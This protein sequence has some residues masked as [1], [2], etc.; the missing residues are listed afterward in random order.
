MTIQLDLQ[1]RNPQNQVF[2]KKRT[3]SIDQIGAMVVDTWNYHWCMTAAERCGSFALR[4]NHALAALRS[5]GVQIFW[6]PTDVADQYVGTPQREK[7]V[8]VEPHP[9][10]TPLDIQFPTLDCYGAGGCMCGSGIDCR[11]NYGWDGM[12]PN[13][14][15]D[16]LDLIVEG[17]QE[18][19]SWCQKL[20]INCLI[21][22]GFHTNVCTTGKP[23]GIGPM[24]RIGIQSILARDMTDAI[25]GY[26][27]SEGQHPDRGT[28]EVIQQL[29]SIVPTIHL[30]DELRKL[31]QWDDETPIDPVRITPWGTLN[32]PYRFEESTVV[33]LSA[34]LNQGCQ[35]YYT[36]DGTPPDEKSSLYTD[37]FPVCET[38]TI[39]TIAYRGHQSIC[40]ES[41]A[42]FVC[43]PS[44]PPPPNIHLSDLEPIRMTVHGF[45]IYSS[46]RKPSCDQSYLQRPLKLRGENYAKGIGV[47]AP[48]HLLYCIQPTYD[49]LVGLAGLDESM[50]ED[51]LGRARA[52]HPSVIFKI[53]INGELADESPT[54]R[55]SQEP[56]RFEVK[57]PSGSRTI[58][59]VAVPGYTNSYENFVNWVD[60][61]FLVK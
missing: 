35:I 37:P 58:S 55:I 4:M 50:L 49:C 46:E 3:F 15:I 29:E 8:A 47:E 2:L 13:L 44:K 40:L 31:G 39:R 36:L 33:S 18:V 59:L 53:Y 14:K 6:G 19:Y 28:K 21:F 10:P 30:V 45:N 34:P 48:S 27:P 61:G 38:Q 24:M 9:L 42:T 60:V 41:S 11:V 57:I 23:V 1:H 52:M 7:S 20:G 43:L 17:T 25:S 5:L 32:R 56:W 54:V 51:E 26:N 12:N 22:L 16:Q